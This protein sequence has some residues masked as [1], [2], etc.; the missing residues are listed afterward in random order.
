[1]S[2]SDAAPREPSGPTLRIVKGD[3]T[4]E[5]IVALIAVLAGRSAAAEEAKPAP[6][7]WTYRRAQLS[8]PV[9]V[10]P[11]EWRRSGFDKGTRT[12]AD[13]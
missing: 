7:A 2:D 5:E 9:F 1:M 4:A 6:S 11:G 3:A 13:W 8:K 10:G 12:K